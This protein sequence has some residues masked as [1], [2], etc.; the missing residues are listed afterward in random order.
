MANNMFK[1]DGII[2]RYR[3]GSLEVWGFSDK[4][5]KRIHLKIPEHLHVT[6]ANKH[7]NVPIS[8]ICKD[9]FNGAINLIQVF[10]PK[11]VTRIG[12]RAFANCINLREVHSE[13]AAPDI[14]IATMAFS[15]CLNLN[16]VKMTRTV[17]FLGS[18]AFG[19]CYGLEYVNMPMKRINNYAFKNCANL[20]RI[21]LAEEAIIHNNT[22]EKTGI[23]ELY[24]FDGFDSI[25]NGVLK[26]IRSHGVILCCPDFSNVCDLACDGFNVVVDVS[27]I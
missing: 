10:I 22:I 6:Y 23:E 19:D 14:E 12:D 17:K 24:F 20:K 21:F 2:Y 15:G 1:C 9:A 8:E 25:S 3:A 18:E 7:M 13:E 26:W 16:T 27:I 4:N 5:D 11:S